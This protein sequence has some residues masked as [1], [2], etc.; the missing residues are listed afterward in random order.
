ML[1][2]IDT[3]T[4]VA[5]VAIFDETRGE[6]WAEC[7]WHSGRNHTREL[8]PEIDR[9]LADCGVQRGDLTGLVVAIGPGSFNGLRVGLTTAKLL[10][11]AL[12]LPLVGVDTLRV[13]AQAFVL[14]GRPIRAMLD[15]GRGQ[16]CTAR[17]VPQGDI[18]VEEEAPRIA[19]LSELVAGPHLPT[20]FCGE[21][22]PEWR[23]AIEQAWGDAAIFPTPG[24]RL[25][26]AAYLAE[27][28][29][30]DLRNGRVD[31]PVTLQPIY[32]RRPYVQLATPPA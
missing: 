25:R 2:A 26:R 31:N 17:Y 9:L 28:G 15:A 8:L 5:S 19:D 23:A 27:L 29:W 14:L 13:S 4:E 11:F 18:L 12:V 22:R 30:R 6:P 1:L 32:L 3:S 16:I 7:T 21:I 10:A 20:V 24:A